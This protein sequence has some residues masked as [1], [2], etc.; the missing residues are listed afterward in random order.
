LDRA[1]KERMGTLV[2]FFVVAPFASGL[3]A[4]ILALILFVIG[5]SMSFSWICGA[6]GNKLS[7]KNV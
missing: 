4:F 3:A 1:L 2:L 6:C 7:G 5:S